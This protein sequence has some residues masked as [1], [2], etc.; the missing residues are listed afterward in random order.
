MLTS[1]PRELNCV[2][3]FCP[4]LDSDQYIAEIS[5]V[6]MSEFVDMWSQYRDEESDSIEDY[7]RAAIAFCWCDEKRERFVTS[8]EDFKACIDLLRERS[9]A[10]TRRLFDPAEAMN[11]FVGVDHSAKKSL[12]ATLQKLRKDAGNGEQL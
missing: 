12:L 10:L 7:K 4:E 6:E 3:V 11:C 1:A 5:G 2:K 9:G 8:Y